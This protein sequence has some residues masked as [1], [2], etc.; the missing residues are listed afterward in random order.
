MLNRFSKQ[1]RAM[2]RAST[3]RSARNKM[4]VPRKFDSVRIKRS[5]AITLGLL[6]PS[7]SSVLHANLKMRSPARSSL[8]ANFSISSRV[9]SIGS[10][11]FKLKR[12][13]EYSAL[14]QIT[15]GEAIISTCESHYR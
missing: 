13:A 12:E 6:P 7:L 1:H 3:M 10:D 8:V 4:T 2:V 11:A 5:T 14:S 9:L 15:S